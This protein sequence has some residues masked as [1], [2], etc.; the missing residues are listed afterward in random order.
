MTKRSAPS[1]ANVGQTAIY[2][3]LSA[4]TDRLAEAAKLSAEAAE[5]FEHGKKN[6]AIGTALPIDLLLSQS[7]ALYDA[8][9]L[10]HRHA[11]RQ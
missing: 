2:C 5:A 4:L 11:N 1:T 8:V 6:L 7:N 3:N 9:I 10:L